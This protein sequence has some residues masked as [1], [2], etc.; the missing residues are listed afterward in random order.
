LPSPMPQPILMAKKPAEPPK[1]IRWNVYKRYGDDRLAQPVWLL[2]LSPSERS[3]I[4]C[5]AC[6]RPTGSMRMAHLQLT[7]RL[8]APNVTKLSID[9]HN[10]TNE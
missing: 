1:A 10:L 8:G 3:S 2:T 5:C 7:H 6:E 4:R 9:Y